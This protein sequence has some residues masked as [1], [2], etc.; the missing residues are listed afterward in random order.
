[1]IFDL[2]TGLRNYGDIVTERFRASS[3]RT[4]S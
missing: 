3:S 4:A 2:G 1:M